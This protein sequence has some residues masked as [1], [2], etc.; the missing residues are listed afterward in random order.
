MPQ[1]GKYVKFKNYERK[2]KSQFII[3]AHF[4]SILAPEDNA[5]QNPEESYT[6]K[7]QKHIAYGYG[8]KLVRAGDKFSNSFK[9]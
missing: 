3:Y 6:K 7:Y 5:R 2:I 9:A 1:I 8:Y 4:E